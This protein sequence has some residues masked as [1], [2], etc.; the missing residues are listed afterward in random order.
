MN[1]NPEAPQS[2]RA[3]ESSRWMGESSMVHLMMRWDPSKLA[4][5]LPSITRSETRTTGRLSAASG[6][7]G[8][9]LVLGAGGPAVFGGGGHGGGT[10]GRGAV[11]VVGFGVAG[12]KAMGFRVVVFG[13]GAAG[14]AAAL[15]RGRGALGAVGGR[16]VVVCLAQD[17]ATVMFRVVFVASRVS[18]SRWRRSAM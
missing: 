7:G 14:V 2:T 9:G 5:E 4:V 17:L 16:V 12:T 11:V 8:R 3:C 18:W 10:W 6:T 1:A 15:G 13:R